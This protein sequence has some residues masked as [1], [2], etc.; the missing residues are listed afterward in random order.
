LTLPNISIANTTYQ[1]ADLFIT[2]NNI[3]NAVNTINANT[4]LQTEIDNIANTYSPNTY[5]NTLVSNTVTTLNASIA[6]KLNSSSYTAADVIAKLIT[7]DG[8]G[9]GLDADLLQGQLASYYLNSTNQVSGTLPNARLSGTYDGMA[10]IT[11]SA[12]LSS[13][14]VN[15]NNINV[16][17]NVTAALVIANGTYITSVNAANLGGQPS[18]YYTNASNFS[19]GTLP[20][21]RLSGTYSFSNLSL[22]ANLTAASISATTYVGLGT[23]STFNEANTA[24]IINNTSGLAI[25]TDKMWASS[26]TVALTDASTITINM[27]TFINATVTLGGNRIIGQPTSTKIGQ[28]G[29]I[30]IVQDGTGSRTASY[31]ADWKWAFGTAPTLS[32][33]ANATDLLF[34]EV[35]AAN[36]VL[37]NLIKG[38]A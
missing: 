29:F 25:S 2:T 13:S 10:N 37:G 17:A 28:T 23:I 11:V 14:V 12:N 18:A 6:T 33:A 9:S 8:T 5:V 19:T 38:V 27:S 34:Y 16:T 35:V 21:G 3:I 32:T 15:T 20:A 30:R 7:V 24:Q 36:F 22:S 1:V 31:H 26:G 4:T